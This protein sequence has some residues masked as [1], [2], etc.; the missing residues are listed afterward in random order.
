V[1]DTRSRLI[2]S[3]VC[4]TSG[5]EKKGGWVYV[6]VF[7]EL[8][9]NL[10]YRVFT[11]PSEGDEGDEVCAVILEHEWPKG[12]KRIEDIHPPKYYHNAKKLSA[13]TRQQ[14]RIKIY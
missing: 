6:S 9:I 12:P 8:R 4:W 11:Q 5:Y 2:T 14:Q 13:A 7:D 3:G 10:P 1:E